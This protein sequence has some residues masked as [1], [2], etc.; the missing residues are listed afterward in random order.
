MTDRVTGSLAFSAAARAVY[1]VGADPDDN[2][3]ADAKMF[4]A[5]KTNLAPNVQ[6]LSFKIESEIVMADGSPI[7]TSRVAWGSATDASADDM[8]RGKDDKRDGRKEGK[9]KLTVW[10]SAFLADGH[11]HPA[12][13]IE[14]AA[15]RAGHDRSRRTFERAAE[16]IGAETR[17]GLVGETGSDWRLPKRH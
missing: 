16:D 17:R 10:L 3:D 8:L 6:A 12:E 7:E 13:I 4:V 14:A 11:W 9:E 1:L 15:K 2:A 5:G